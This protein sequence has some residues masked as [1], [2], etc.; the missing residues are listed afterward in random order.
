MRR[1]LLLAMAAGLAACANQPRHEAGPVDDTPLSLIP[2]P[3]QLQRTPGHF[4]LD[5]GTPISVALGDT[6]ANRVAIQLQ[7]WIRQAR[8]FTPAIVAGKPG[9]GGIALATVSSIKGREAYTLDVDGSGVRIAAN[10]ETGLFYGAVTYWQLLT[11]PAAQ[12]GVPGVH[13][14]DAPRFEWRGLML[15]SSRHFQSV[16]EIEHLLDQMAM[17]KLNTF[18]W[19]L[20]DDQGWRLQIEKYP[21]LTE[22]GA[23][24]QPV[25]PDVALTGDPA[26]P[27][28]GFYTQDEAKQIVAYAAERHITV[29]PEIEM[30]GHAQAAVAAYPKFGAGGK[31]LPVSSDW[32]VNTALYNVDDGTFVFLQDVLDEVMAVFPSTYIHVGGDEA[33]KDEWERSKTVQAKMKSLGIADEEQM[34]GWFIARVGDYLEKHG[35][36]LIGWDEILDGKVPASATVMS[37]RGT[38]GAIKAAN[39]GHDVVL[40]PSPTLYLDQLQSSL[41]DEQPG[42]PSGQTLKTLYDFDPVP[43]EIA[44]DKASHVLGAQVTVFSEYLPNWYRTQHAI[45]PRMAALAER[46]WSPKADWSS[47]IARLPAQMSRY[48]AAGIVPSD[49]AY[50]VAIQAEAAGEDQAKVTLSN[51]SGYGTLRYTTDGSAPTSQSTAYGGPFDVPLPTTVRANAFAGGFGLAGPR[52]REIDAKSLLHRTSD[53]LDTCSDKLVLRLESPNAVNGQRPV[54]KVDIMDTCWVWKGVKLDGRYGLAVTVDRLPYN[55]ALW[56]DAKGIVARKAR[57]GAGELEVHQDTCDGPKLASLPLAKAKDGRATL[58]GVLPKREGTHDLCFVVTGKPG[59][60]LWV[61]GDVQLR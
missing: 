57:S 51:Q 12:N 36:R 22:T 52:D 30:P 9:N 29:V 61:L 23:C 2:M 45:F 46:T 25:G 59:P 16:N 6:Q 55:Y 50:A 42:R 18:H 10:D 27:Y 40:A 17:H 28:C 43:A 41:P 33:A 3:A 20:T 31:K 44:P 38:K 4:R 60:K 26:H 47:F 32:G 13:I 34:Q 35:R 58:D 37:W 15:D 14:V 24:R 8:G 56:K 11:D 54:Y 5:A 49:G 21:R 7:G 1:I 48:R 19:H 39:A 53:E